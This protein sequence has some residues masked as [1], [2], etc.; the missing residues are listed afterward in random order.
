MKISVI[1]VS[2]ILMI[3]SSTAKADGQFIKYKN[4]LIPISTSCGKPK[5]IVTTDYAPLP[6]SADEQVGR[7]DPN[8]VQDMVHFLAYSNH[9]NVRA[10]I[11][12]MLTDNV[13]PTTAALNNTLTRYGNDSQF[14]N[15]DAAREY[16]SEQELKSVVH[17]GVVSRSASSSAT[18]QIVI[19]A[20]NASEACP[21]NIL[22]WGPITEV[23]S[24]LDTMPVGDRNNVRIIAIGSTNRTA[25]PGSWSFVQSRA[26]NGETT[27]ITSDG[28]GVQDAFRSLSRTSIGDCGVINPNFYNDAGNVGRVEDIMDSLTDNRPV[29]DNG[30]R[31]LLQQSR[32]SRSE[33]RLANWQNC[34]ANALTSANSLR[35][36]DSL[37][38]MYLLDEVMG[39]DGALQQIIENNDGSTSTGARNPAVLRQ[40]YEHYQ[41]RM[42]Q[43]YN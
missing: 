24:A 15:S 11:V 25:D 42:N 6:S 33:I 34:Q 14:F 38:T 1:C 30:L 18:Q 16:P 28:R 27:F 31:G 2:I 8:E 35:M 43:I 41:S 21:V 22:V 29:T 37:T 5:V 39:F 19:E 23:A 13:L 7:S 12:S 26:N 3:I 4:Y 40:I 9:F 10:L 32:G 20:A 36:G 17:R